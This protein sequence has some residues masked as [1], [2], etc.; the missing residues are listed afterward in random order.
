MISLSIIHLKIETI[1]V[2]V[3]WHIMSP[4]DCLYKLLLLFPSQ[5]WPGPLLL[6][7]LVRTSVACS[8]FCA[9]AFVAF[10]CISLPSLSIHLSLVS[11]L[12]RGFYRCFIISELCSNLF[13]SVCAFLRTEGLVSKSRFESQLK[14]QLPNFIVK[15][16]Y[17][18]STWTVILCLFSFHLL[19]LS[20]SVNNVAV[21][22]MCLR[23]VIVQKY[24]WDCTFRI[25]Y[26]YK[27]TPYYINLYCNGRTRVPSVK[28]LKILL[29]AFRRY[30][31][32][33]Q[34]WFMAFPEYFMLQL[35]LNML[36][37]L[38]ITVMIFVLRY[39]SINI[40]ININI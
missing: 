6:S 7:C 3:P 1:L 38:F 17:V 13:K 14:Y 19:P 26:C 35:W 11:V 30:L 37:K 20:G 8:Q 39:V 18:Q 24:F 36:S 16:K 27:R 5:I 40:I 15:D 33:F 22:A 32:V 4:F 21:A 25:P 34:M 28:C 9:M 31:W 12:I 2:P 29:W 23:V 10:C